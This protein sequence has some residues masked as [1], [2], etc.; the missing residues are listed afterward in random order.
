MTDSHDYSNT[1]TQLEGINETNIN[2]NHEPLLPGNSSSSDGRKRSRTADESVG[3]GSTLGAEEAVAP[4]DVDERRTRIALEG[5]WT[6]A[7]K[8]L[9]STLSVAELRAMNADYEERRSERRNDWKPKHLKAQFKILCTFALLNP[10]AR[11]YQTQLL[12]DIMTKARSEPERLTVESRGGACFKET[13][14]AAV[15]S[16][17]VMINDLLRTMRRELFS[18]LL[19]KEVDIAVKVARIRVSFMGKHKASTYTNDEKYGLVLRMALLA[20]WLSD[21]HSELQAANAEK[22]NSSSKK[23]KTKSAQSSSAH[24]IKYD[25]AVW[26]R[27]DETLSGIREGLSENEAQSKLS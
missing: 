9:R 18:I 12:D 23:R 27:V 3:E 15:A 16:V 8:E 22:E 25:P 24:T 14:P 2:D 1:N 7:E 6:S 26:I 5:N 19:T 10:N 4:A 13:D 11:T 20:K 17:H 21:S